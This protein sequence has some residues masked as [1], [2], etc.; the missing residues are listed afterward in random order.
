MKI[1]MK[2]ACWLANFWIRE[3]NK[4]MKQTNGQIEWNKWITRLLNKCGR[5]DGLIAELTCAMNSVCVLAPQIFE[6]FIGR[7]I[8]RIRHADASGI[9]QLRS[10]TFHLSNQLSVFYS[11][12]SLSFFLLIY[13]LQRDSLKFRKKRHIVFSETDKNCWLKQPFLALN[14][15]IF[16]GNWQ[17]IQIS[18]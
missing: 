8:W 14:D 11:F 18:K 16:S 12:F 1:L 6:M 4:W 5:V 15:E 17:I 2:I 10:Q 9:H 7:F 3:Q 13:R